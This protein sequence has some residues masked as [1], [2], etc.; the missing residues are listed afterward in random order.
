M[1]KIILFISLLL[2]ALCVVQAKDRVF[3]RP[4]FIAW[5]STSIEI[6]KI[7]AKDTATV[8]HIKAF[9]RPKN[10][11]KIATGSVLK[12]NNGAIYPIR[13]G[14]G[15]TL[16][17][18]FWMPESGEAEF[19]LIF[20]PIPYNITSLDFS[21]GDF[22]GA[23]RIWGIQLDEKAFRKQAIPQNVTVHK[24]NKKAEL[25]EPEF[26]Y[27]IATLKGKVLGFQPEMPSTGKLSLNDPIRWSSFSEDITIREDGTFETQ[28]D[29]I[30]VTPAVIALPTGNIQC[31]LAPGKE[32]SVTINLPEISRQK[33][34]LLKD[35]KPFGKQAYFEGYLAALQQE[36][37]DNT[38][39]TNIIENPQ[40]LLKEIVGKDINACKVYFIDKR[41]EV[42]EQISNSPMSLAA[43]EVLKA[44]ANITT[45]IGLFMAKSLVMRAHVEQQKL[46]REQTTEYYKNNQIELPT[47][48]YDTLKELSLNSLTNL[49]APEYAYGVIVFSSQ[50]AIVQSSLHTDKGILFDM[51]KALQYYS[52][53]GEFIPLNPQQIADL[54]TFP[55]AAYKELLMKVN[56]DLLQKIELNK[57]K[58]GFTIHQIGDVSNEELFASIIS[59]FKGHVLLVDFWATWCGPCR[60]ANKAMIPMKEELK[61]KDVLYV[62]ITGETSP[63]GTWENMIPDIHGEHF[64]VSN[65]Q[66]AYLMDKYEVKGVPTYYIIDRKGD[67]TYKQTGFPGVDEMK[68]QV[69]KAL[70]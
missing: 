69:E 56:E 32:T 20:P 21:E 61:D 18:E 46:N 45:G 7:V 8:V 9:Y 39:Q 42:L 48:Y 13:R 54:S 41:N 19:E 1:K 68:K 25:P 60:M 44:N 12:D 34:K 52:S 37:A 15:I 30:T 23:F 53:I 4:P 38:I 67:T 64:R 70:E 11:I 50:E 66:W 28:V 6:D 33:S 29:L 17:K 10:W 2:A 3:E 49:Y 24:I 26:M 22:D 5:S 14:V 63:Q 57:Q 16:D 65:A 36:L 40:T 35:T 62:Y 43:K 51:G 59:K 55:S 47:D 27:G 58:S 31:L